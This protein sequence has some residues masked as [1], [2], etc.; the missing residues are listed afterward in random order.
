MEKFA[1]DS[2]EVRKQMAENSY[3]Y[4]QQN[5]NKNKFLKNVMNILEED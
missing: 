1:N 2:I 4:Y 5:F 3:N